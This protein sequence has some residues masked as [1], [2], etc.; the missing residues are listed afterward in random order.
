MLS[1]WLTTCDQG[2]CG[3]TCPCLARS[4][5]TCSCQDCCR[6]QLGGSQRGCWFLAAARILKIKTVHSPYAF[7][8]TLSFSFFECHC[9]L[10]ACMSRCSTPMREAASPELRRQPGGIGAA[11]ASLS[12]CFLARVSIVQAAPLFLRATHCHLSPPC[13]PLSAAFTLRPLADA[14]S[15]SPPSPSVYRTTTTS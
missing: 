12:D 10:H 5:P 14:H 15:A 13:L 6:L 2:Q 3:H 11:S 8:T 9:C 1:V 4:P 7:S